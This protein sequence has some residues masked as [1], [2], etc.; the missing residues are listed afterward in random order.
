MPEYQFGDYAYEPVD[1]E[2]SGSI[3]LRAPRERQHRPRVAE[4]PGSRR[5]YTQGGLTGP[6][7]STLGGVLIARGGDDIEG[8]WDAFMAAHA[9]GA[10]QA[11]YLDRADRYLLAEVE[12]LRDVD[13][14]N[15]VGAIPWEVQ[16]VANDPLWRGDTL[17]TQAATVAGGGLSASLALAVGGTAPARLL[18]TYTLAA[19]GAVASPVT[20]LLTVT[21]TT[22]GKSAVLNAKETGAAVLYDADA[23]RLIRSGV[24]ATALLLVGGWLELAPGVTNNLTLTCAGGAQLT[25]ASASWRDRWW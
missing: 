3:I 4:A 8:L 5:H 6:V 22:T 9:D 12:A 11:L 24:D 18:L 10:P 19:V 1:E 7:R 21:N 16:F 14:E 20:S 2:S 15:S 23:E 17:N 25:S 13:A